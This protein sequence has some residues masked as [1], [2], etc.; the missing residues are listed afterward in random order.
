MLAMQPSTPRVPPGYRPPS[1]PLCDEQGNFLPGV[2][3]VPAKR[4]AARMWHL[5]SRRDSCDEPLRELL[6]KA[7][8]RGILWSHPAATSGCGASPLMIA[9]IM[10]HKSAVAHLLAYRSADPA[11]NKEFIDKQDN[12]GTTALM[13]AACKGKAGCV[14]HLLAAGAAPNIQNKRGY[15]ALEAAVDM[16]HGECTSLL[17]AHGARQPASPRPGTAKA[18][19]K[20]SGEPFHWERGLSN[21]NWWAQEG[22]P[23]QS[24]RAAELDA[25]LTQHVL[26]SVSD[27]HL[28]ETPIDRYHQVEKKH[29]DRFR[30]EQKLKETAR[31][32]E[33]LRN[34]TLEAW[35]E[36]VL[37]A[38]LRLS[39]SREARKNLQGG[40]FATV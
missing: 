17:L 29:T 7:H 6:E 5:A 13:A 14:G 34:S 9:C 8:R 31:E 40:L 1:L 10:G 38:S 12:F 35:N 18:Q 20:R 16:G 19:C 4:V 26:G 30:T 23:K 37:S 11:Y 22:L 32:R 36:R 33:A 15:T 27:A 39:A 24:R 21:Q 28:L 25:Q 3:A 2:S